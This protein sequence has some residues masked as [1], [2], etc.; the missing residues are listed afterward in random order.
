MTN[1]ARYKGTDEPAGLWIGEATEFAEEIEKAGM[2]VDYVS[3][4]GGFVP[5]DPRSMKYMDEPILKFYEQ[6]DFQKR[7][8]SASLKPEDVDPDDYS[9]IYY[10][11]GHGVM[12]D[13]PDNEALQNISS[14][15][16]E[17]DGFVTSVCHG[18]AGL[19]NIK[20]FDGNYIVAGK[21]V[22]GFT[23]AEEVLAGKKSVVPFM[24]QERAE[25]RGA[26]FEK[27]RP[28]KEFVVQDERII[29]GQ[30]PFSVRAVAK[31]LIK[32]M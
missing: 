23:K 1:I 20:N 4:K 28:Y 7:A 9:A 3:P 6:E 22:T 26:H 18:I 30:N 16:Y 21:T 11:G 27:K 25:E 31:Q 14:T 5:L 32:S 24:N 15:I 13:F 17:K 10:S 19:F 8:L 12:W 2:K 29:T